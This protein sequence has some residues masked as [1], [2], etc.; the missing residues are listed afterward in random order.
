MA[1]TLACAGAKRLVMH[2]PAGGTDCE[3]VLFCR[4]SNF[5]A[6]CADT[7]CEGKRKGT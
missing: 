5:V 4:I 1:D 3:Q 6:G 7:V 2:V